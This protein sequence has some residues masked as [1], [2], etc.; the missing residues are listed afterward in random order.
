M[1]HSEEFST[2]QSGRAASRDE[3]SPRAAEGSSS[4]G[5]R[6][7]SLSSQF[8]EWSCGDL[9]SLTASSPAMSQHGDYNEEE[10]ELVT[11]RPE[12]TS[13]KSHYTV[14]VT[15]VIHLAA[16]CLLLWASLS[17]LASELRVS[18]WIAFGRIALYLI[19]SVSAWNVHCSLSWARAQGHLRW[20]RKTRRHRDTAMMIFN[21]VRVVRFNKST[22]QSDIIEKEMASSTAG[23]TKSMGV[24]ELVEYQDDVIEHLVAQNHC[25]SQRLLLLHTNH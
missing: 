9:G 12:T 13:I 15:T 18:R 25:L 24:R 20:E 8:G 14:F 4:L 3:Q 7:K 21:T 19:H 23:T 5:H 11:R 1:P 10:E 17:P 22:P 16:V 6:T 2:R